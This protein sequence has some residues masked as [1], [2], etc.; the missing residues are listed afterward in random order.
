MRPAALGLI[1][2]FLN[3]PLTSQAITWKESLKQNNSW[4]SS[5][6]AI[7][8][9]DNLLLYQR[10][11]GGWPKNTDFAKPLTN[12][13]RDR[14]IGQK[15]DRT[16]CTIDN[17]ATYRPIRFL[18]SVYQATGESRFHDAVEKGLRFLL[19]IQY[20]NGGWPQFPYK[21]GY[22]THIT[23][24][25]DA[26]IGVLDLLRDVEEA[27]PPF[28]FIAPELRNQS[29]RAIEKGVACILKC[30]VTVDGELTVWCAQHDEK[31]LQ[32]APARSYEK[33]SLSGSESEKIVEFLMGIESPS[34]EV[35]KSIRQAVKWFEKSKIEGIR[36]VDIKGSDLPE[37]HDRVVVE[38]SS[39]PPLW[40]RFYEIGSNRPIF[41]GRDGLIKYN[42]SEIEHERRNGYSWYTGRPQSLL[43]RYPEWAASL[44]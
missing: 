28:E 41:C 13:E 7:G 34:P 10:D 8:V 27:K 20:D 23:F 3:L 18:A 21:K 43:E 9:A 44:K 32:P 31:T 19:D 17:G 5:S 33:I 16:D 37:G 4:Y 14:L 35:V 40:A 30:Q 24:N 29:R 12:E 38:D 2:L 39:A 22:Y 6:E 36:V 25:D 26:M 15:S 1:V 42:L 11:A